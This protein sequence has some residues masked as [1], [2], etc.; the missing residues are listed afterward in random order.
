M[1]KNSEVGDEKEPKMTQTL[2]IGTLYATYYNMGRKIS[3]NF[4]H[5]LAERHSNHI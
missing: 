5:K 3:K 4:Y 2:N 1:N